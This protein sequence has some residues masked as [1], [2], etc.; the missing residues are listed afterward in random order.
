VPKL[1]CYTLF[2]FRLD[3]ESVL[4]EVAPPRCWR[5]ENAPHPSKALAA[6]AFFNLSTDLVAHIPHLSTDPLI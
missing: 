4:V 5:L 2:V 6:S 1:T 3:R